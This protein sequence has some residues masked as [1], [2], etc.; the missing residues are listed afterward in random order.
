[1]NKYNVVPK[2]AQLIGAIHQKDSETK[3]VKNIIAKNDQTEEII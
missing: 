3:G 2:I 1:M